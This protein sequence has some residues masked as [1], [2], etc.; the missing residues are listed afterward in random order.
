MLKSAFEKRVRIAT[1]FY[2]KYMLICI[3]CLISQ[4]QRI[5]ITSSCGAIIDSLSPSKPSTVFSERDWNENAIK[6][7]K[8]MGD[9]A[10]PMAIYLA[11][12]T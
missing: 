12:K 9:K 11:L 3:R 10:S 6:E 8:E 7:V 4:V 1:S 5:V 2:C